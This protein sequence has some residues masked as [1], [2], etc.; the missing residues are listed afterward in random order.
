MQAIT[1]IKFYTQ[2]AITFKFSLQSIP[3][4]FTPNLFSKSFQSLFHRYLNSLPNPVPLFAGIYLG[5]SFASTS[6]Y[7]H[8][9]PYSCNAPLHANKLFQFYPCNSSGIPIWNIFEPY[10]LHPITSN[11]YPTITPIT[12][13]LVPFKSSP[14]PSLLSHPR[15]F[16]ILSALPSKFHA[17][18]KSPSLS[19][20]FVFT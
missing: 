4:I 1:V 16:S 6:I 2:P 14:N 7:L 11:H 19:Q 17:P 20:I 13:Y 5:I 12:H 9:I 3:P 10:I 18:L 15:S 8:P